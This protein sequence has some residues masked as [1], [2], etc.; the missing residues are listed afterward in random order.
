MS[1]PINIV[2]ILTDQFRFDCLGCLGHPLLKTPNLD[3]MAAQG[4]LFSRAYCATMPCGP[5][6]TSIFTGRYADTHKA[7]DNQTT[8]APPD[9]P[10]LPE[11]LK[12]LGYETALVGKLHLK[13]FNRRFGF[14]H[15][16]RS[17]APYTNYLEEEATES[18]YIRFLQAT[19]FKD[20][21]EQAIQVFTDDEDCLESNEMRFMLGSNPVD[22]E[23]HITTWT[24]DE[25]VQLLEHG[26]MEPFFLNVS[27]FGPHQPYL[28]PAPWDALYPA[29][30]L[31]LPEDFFV[32]PDSRRILMNSFHRNLIQR[33]EHHGWD[34]QAYRQ[35]LS[36][37]Y[38]NISMIDHA[39]GRLMD[40]LKAGGLL[41]RTLVVFTA[42]HG[43][44]AGQFGTFYKGLGYE[45]SAHVPLIVQ[46]PSSPP[47]GTEVDSPVNNMDLFATLLSIAGGT[48]PPDTESRDF[49][50]LLSGHTH[51]WGND[52]FFKCGANAFLVQDHLKVMRDQVGGDTVYEMFDLD[53][54]P[55]EHRDLCHAPEY[56]SIFESLKQ[57]LDAWFDAQAALGAD[58]PAPKSIAAAPDDTGAEPPE[59]GT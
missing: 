44:Y 52:T 47:R 37:Y 8:M 20:R 53:E 15:F 34:A 48:P 2:F 19:C 40:A 46:A 49:S 43:D 50:C 57:E 30:T 17:D 7:K 39:V 58:D 54:R 13:P 35:I 16:L 31:P 3:A 12:P 18:A 42:D 55:L 33:R 28:C 56:S 51:A 32:E 27:F 6:R 25:S 10:V 23:H 14:D 45:G 36:A 59:S 1:T 21:P 24:A 38:G 26:L 41:D 5:A 29:D 11:L 4:T 22:A 9:R